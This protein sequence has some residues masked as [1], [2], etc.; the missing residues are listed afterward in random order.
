IVPE[1]GT[2]AMMILLVGIMATVVLT[3]NR[4]QMKI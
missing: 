4:F 3:K 2:I 1:F